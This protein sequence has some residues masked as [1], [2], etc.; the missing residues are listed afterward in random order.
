M[1]READYR[2]EDGVRDVALGQMR[3]ARWI[4]RTSMVDHPTCVCVAPPSPRGRLQEHGLF[5]RI[6]PSRALLLHARGTLAILL[7]GVVG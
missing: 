6:K 1:R 5:P 2:A 7:V 4:M 3:L